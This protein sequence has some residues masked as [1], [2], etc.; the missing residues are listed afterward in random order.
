MQCIV[1]MAKNSD[2]DTSFWFLIKI[3]IRDI[4]YINL[5][6]YQIVSE[7]LINHFN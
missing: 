3:T 2:Y 4:V 6:K 5:L 7:M 1:E